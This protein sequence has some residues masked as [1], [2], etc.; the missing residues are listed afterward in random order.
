MGYSTNPVDA[1]PVDKLE[2]SQED[3]P[4]GHVKCTRPFVQSVDKSARSPLNPEV[5]DLSIAPN[6]SQPKESDARPEQTSGK[7]NY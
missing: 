4:K 5:T 7:P 3:T 6:A 1:L 2:S